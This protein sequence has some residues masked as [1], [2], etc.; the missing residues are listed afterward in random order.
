MGAQRTTS[1]GWRLRHCAWLA[2]LLFGCKV[3]NPDLL[4][5]W[6]GPEDAGSLPDTGSDTGPYDAGYSGE[7]DAG[8]DP[9]VGCSA[10]EGDL[11]C[12]Q[13]CPETCNDRDDDCDGVI[14]ESDI[15]LCQL[16]AATSVCVAGTCLIAGC[17]EG[18]V[19]CNELAA[20][21]CEATLDSVEHCGVCSQRCSLANADPRCNGG[22]CEVFG[23]KPSFG[24]CD[25]RS[26]N[27]CERPLNSLLDC[28]AC[29]A[30][31]AAAHAVTDCSSGQCKFIQCAP[32]YGDCNNDANRL[33]AGDGCETQLNTE[34]H[35]GS[36]AP[37]SGTLKCYG[38]KCTSLVCNAD[39][40][41]CDGNNSVCETSLRSVDDC[42]SCGN[43]CGS[44]A[45]AAVSCSTGNC[46]QTCNS[47]FANCDNAL[48]NG[49]E[50]NIRTNTNC[51][52]CGTTCTY[53]N[54]TTSCTS[55][56][57]QLT[58]CTSGFGDCNGN[59]ADG[60]EQRLNTTTHCNGCGTACTRANATPTCSSGSCQVSS[61]NSGFGNCDGNAANGCETNLQTSAQHCNGC[62]QGCTSN[63]SCQAG[64]CVCTSDSNCGSGQVCCGGA[65]VS[66]GSDEANCGG[67][68]RACASN[69][70]CCSGSCKTLSSDRSN[71]GSCGNQCDSDDTNTCSN[72]QCRCSGDPPCSGLSR[73]CSSGCKIGLLCF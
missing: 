26:D 65:C 31:C 21:G 47:G 27:G 56:T 62:G 33:G 41:D 37:C 55:G 15:P 44:P 66:T 69:Q 28:G 4:V 14:D 18:N 43:A 67:C 35:C 30:G 64:R 12:P 32:G 16:S 46:V 13:S 72:G 70:T 51:G 10:R 19:D 11:D 71:C 59:A 5:Q 3:Y 52:A 17:N 42:G 20:D 60:C 48:S 68:G 1:H 73:C 24:D 25:K 23:C 63:F 38:G 58:T 45:N 22:R 29:G 54:A 40:A 53:A 61:C 39:E 34:S 9:V 49:C 50:T 7:L 57:C 2:C 6:P 36:C 8:D